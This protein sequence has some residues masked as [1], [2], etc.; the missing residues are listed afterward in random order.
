MRGAYDV[1]KRQII[2]WLKWVDQD[3]YDLEAKPTAPAGDHELMLMLQTLLSE[4]FKLVFHREQRPIPGYRLVKG[5]LKA[6][7]SAPIAA[8]S[9]IHRQGASRPKAVPWLRWPSSWRKC[10]PSRC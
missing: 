2:G 7:V 5:G 8:A 10:L 4:R 1:A 9:A 3:R 6:Q